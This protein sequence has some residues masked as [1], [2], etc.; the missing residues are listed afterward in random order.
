[1]QDVLWRGVMLGLGAG[2]LLALAGCGG[3]GTNKLVPASAT[4]RSAL[5]TALDTWQKGGKQGRVA[6]GPPVVQ[7]LDVKWAAG[8]KLAKYEI[9]EELPSDGPPWFSVKLTMQSPPGEQVVKYVVIGKDPLWV[10]RE[11]D[12]KKLSGM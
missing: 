10:Y 11:E 2:L 12:Y 5:E 1:M 7:A 4:A 8:Q 3:R 6:E 9:L